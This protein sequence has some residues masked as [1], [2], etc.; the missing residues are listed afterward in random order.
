MQTGALINCGALLTSVVVVV[1][2]QPWVGESEVRLDV[3]VHWVPS[4]FQSVVRTVVRP[5]D[6]VCTPPT[7]ERRDA[8][9]RVDLQTSLLT[10]CTSYRRL[11]GVTWL[12][13]QRNTHTHTHTHTRTRTSST[14]VSRGNELTSDRSR[15]YMT[16]DGVLMSYRYWSWQWQGWP[17]W[18]LSG[19]STPSYFPD[20]PSSSL[21]C[22]L[23]G[24]HEPP[25]LQPCL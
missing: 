8:D 7:P 9:S 20:P 21:H 11:A 22:T 12:S 13:T 3:E 5:Y 6:V 4:D 17:E 2:W 18:E 24:W 10:C 23:G 1:S 15:C 25:Q 16:E 19:G 14:F